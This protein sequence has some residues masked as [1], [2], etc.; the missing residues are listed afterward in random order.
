MYN[1]CRLHIN[2]LQVYLGHNRDH[3][4]DFSKKYHW[5]KQGLLL[6]AC[7]LPVIQK[8]PSG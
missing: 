7:V 1:N 8:T 2:I 5:R 4:V 6:R 3:N